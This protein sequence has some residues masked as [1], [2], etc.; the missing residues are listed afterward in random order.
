[1]PGRRIPARY[2]RHRLAMIRKMRRRN[3]YK[4]RGAMRG[5]GFLKIIRKLPIITASNLLGTAGSLAA[6]D[7][8]GSCLT[9]GTPVAKTGYTQVYDVPFSLQFQMDQ[10]VNY[11]ELTAISDQYKLKNVMVRLECPFTVAQAPGGTATPLPYIEYIQDSDDSGVPNVAS[12]R[13][14]M[15]LTTKYFSSN[16]PKITMGVNPK[17]TTLLYQSGLVNGYAVSR[18]AWINCSSPAIPHYG[19]KGVLRN[20]WIPAVSNGSPFTFDISTKLYLKDIQ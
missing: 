12:F 6:T 3:L 18:Q 7:P 8:T 20:V 16:K 13:E 9:L 10:L 15:G 1:M 14:R 17:T 2:R 11:V 4:K 5:N 19:I